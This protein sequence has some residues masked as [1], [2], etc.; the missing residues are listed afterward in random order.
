MSDS[1]SK[2]SQGFEVAHMGPPD[3]AGATNEPIDVASD[4]LAALHLTGNEGDQPAMEYPALS[5]WPT[6]TMSPGLHPPS[7]TR[8]MGGTRISGSSGAGSI[9]GSRSHA[10]SSDA[11]SVSS[12]G[13]RRGGIGKR[14]KRNKGTKL[15][16]AAKPSVVA[17]LHQVETEAASD[18]YRAPS[19]TSLGDGSGTVRDG[20]ATYQS[21]GYLAQLQSP[22]NVP[23][24]PLNYGF[25]APDPNTPLYGNGPSLSQG[26]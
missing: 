2:A 22:S 10:D 6:R 11:G 9:A 26:E 13:R 1:P 18:I 16:G 20:V 14:H 15:T 12:A 17:A 8:L 24:S 23:N 19:G 4:D 5:G 21:Q 3:P 25:D 7:A